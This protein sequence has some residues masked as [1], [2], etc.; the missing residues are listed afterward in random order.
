MELQNLENDRSVI[1]A[2][3]CQIDC[4]LYASVTYRQMKRVNSVR[5]YVPDLER[6][7]TC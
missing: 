6:R 4:K 1:S 5:W 7:R 2:S 3:A